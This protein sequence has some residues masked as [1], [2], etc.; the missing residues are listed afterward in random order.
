MAK[1]SI[2]RKGYTCRGEL[3]KLHSFL[4]RFVF[5]VLRPVRL[6]SLVAV[7]DYQWEN[8]L[9]WRVETLQAA[10]ISLICSEIFIRDDFGSLMKIAAGGLLCKFDALFQLNIQRCCSRLPTWIQSMI[11]NLFY[12]T[13]KAWNYFPYTTTEYTVSLCFCA[14]LSLGHKRTEIRRWGILLACVL[15]GFFAVGCIVAWNTHSNPKVS[16]LHCASPRPPF[17]GMNV[18]LWPA[19]CRNSRGLGGITRCLIVCRCHA[20]VPLTPPPLGKSSEFVSDQCLGILCNFSS[21][22]FETS[23]TAN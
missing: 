2:Q 13:E 17:H 18:V 8:I 14:F 7:D 12:V 21:L 22:F 20:R 19:A 9:T 16:I 4:Y 3:E 10:S 15:V 5:S 6:T 23:I 11:P 1:D